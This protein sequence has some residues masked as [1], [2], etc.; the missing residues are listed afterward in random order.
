MLQGSKTV[1]IITHGDSTKRV[2]VNMFIIGRYKLVT[3]RK[4]GKKT[5]VNVIIHYEEK[6]V[7]VVEEESSS[8]WTQVHSLVKLFENKLVL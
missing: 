1:S 8:P 7:N 4:L 2:G 6:R 5:L 3:R